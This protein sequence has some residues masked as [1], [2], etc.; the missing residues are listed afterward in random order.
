[1]KA[2]LPR[3]ELVAL[4]GKIQNIVP[5]KPAHPVL[6]NVLVEAACD[7]VVLSVT[8]LAVSVRAYI[9]AKVLEEGGIALPAKRLFHLIRELTTPQIELHCTSPETASLNAGSS[10]FKIQGIHKSEFPALPDAAEGVSFT[11][12]NLLLK[13]MLGRTAF[14]IAREDS[15]QAINGLL[16]HIHESVASFVA[17]DGKRLARLHTPVEVPTGHTGAYILS[18]KS[19]DEMIKILEVKDGGACRL[20]LMKDKVALETGSMTL[21][22]SLLPGPYPDFSRIIPGKSAAPIHLHREELS[23]LLKQVGVF[24]T[25]EH[26]MARFSFH[27]GVLH[28]AAMNGEVGEG[29]V[30]MPVNYGGPPLEV[31]FNPHAFLDALRHSRDEVVHF[32]ITDPYAPS[33]ITDSTSA[34]FMLMPMRCT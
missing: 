23:A 1:M 24:T 14:A 32:S 25:E 26:T 9:E 15:R 22:A 30:S 34:Q 28:L 10:H 20:T 6:H 19:V 31:G 13:E 18:S 16:L 3:P 7:Q 27:T 2:I 17:T 21:F 5:A 8:D 4:I 11:I 12:T 29:N 33:L